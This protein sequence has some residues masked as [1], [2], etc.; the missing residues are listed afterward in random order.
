MENLHSIANK[1]AQIDRL[2]NKIA[3]HIL[4]GEVSHSD[5]IRFIIS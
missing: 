1:M 5:D 2:I 4:P 3:C